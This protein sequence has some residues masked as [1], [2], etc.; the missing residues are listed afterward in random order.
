MSSFWWSIWS[1]LSFRDEDSFPLYDSDASFYL[2][3][4]LITE[5][6]Y[7]LSGLPQ[8]LAVWGNRACLTT[9]TSL[10]EKYTEEQQ[11]RL[12]QGRSQAKFNDLM[13]YYTLW[14]RELRHPLQLASSWSKMSRHLLS[15]SRWSRAFSRST[16]MPIWFCSTAIGEFSWRSG[17]KARVA[18]T[19]SKVV[20]QICPLFL[21]KRTDSEPWFGCRRHYRSPEWLLVIIRQLLSNSLKYTST[22]GIE[23]YFKDQTLYIKTAGWNPK[24]RCPP[25]SLSRATPVTMAT[26]PSNPQVWGS[27]CLRKSLRAGGRLGS[28]P[29]RGRSRWPLPLLWRERGLVMD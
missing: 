20:L 5:F 26:W 6:R 4:H 14:V 2:W 3:Q 22:G 16:P 1:L 27:I 11:A 17:L 23:I 28:P 7:D 15:S 9:G 8:S 12:E 18:R 19:W 10:Y 25:V 29:F 21:S 13:D 24:T